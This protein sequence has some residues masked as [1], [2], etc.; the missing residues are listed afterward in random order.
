M[1]ELTRPIGSHGYPREAARPMKDTAWYIS[2]APQNTTPLG[3]RLQSMRLE[4]K[5]P[6]IPI[7][8]ETQLHNLI[9]PSIEL[10]RHRE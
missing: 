3:S 5:H 2:E 8:K 9:L 10:L 6:S 7:A 1:E 4:A